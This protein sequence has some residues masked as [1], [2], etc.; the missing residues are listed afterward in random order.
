MRAFYGPDCAPAWGTA[1]DSLNMSAALALLARA[2]E[3]GLSPADYHLGQLLAL[4]DSLGRARRPA[5]ARQARLDVYLSDAVLA[6]VRDLRRGRLRPYTVS[7]GSGL[8]GR[9]GSRAQCCAPPLPAT[10]CPR[11]CWP[12]SPPTASTGSCSRPW[13]SGWLPPCCPTRRPGTRRSTSWWP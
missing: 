7:G 6:F 13:R 3:H 2:A 5:A 12:A 4:R 8:P 11:P 10:M 1:P 9:P